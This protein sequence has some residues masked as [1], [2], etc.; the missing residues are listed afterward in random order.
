MLRPGRPGVGDLD[1]A[2]CVKEWWYHMRVSWAAFRLRSEIRRYAAATWRP[3]TVEE[4][5]QLL[6]R[7]KASA[8]DHK[9]GERR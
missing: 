8:N 4:Q 7:I 5:E 6:R 9:E 2:P 1:R 3:M